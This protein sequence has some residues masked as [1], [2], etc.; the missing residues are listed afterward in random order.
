M[1]MRSVLS[2]VTALL[3]VG[4]FY[5][6]SYCIVE[7]V[8]ENAISAEYYYATEPE[9]TDDGNQ[10][11]KRKASGTYNDIVIHIPPVFNEDVPQNK[12][13]AETEAPSDENEPET[14]GSQPLPDAGGNAVTTLPDEVAD[15]GA[16]TPVSDVSNSNADDAPLADG[17]EDDDEELTVADEDGEII[18]EAEDNEVYAGD[19]TIDI[20]LASRFAQTDSTTVTVPPEEL[21]GDSPFIPAADIIITVNNEDMFSPPPYEPTAVNTAGETLYARYNGSVHTADAYELICMIVNNEVSASFNDEA[22]KAQAV[23]AYS[24]V[25]YHN[26]N[27]LTPTVLVKSNPPQIIKDLVAEVMGT[28]CYYGG[29]VAQTVYM[30]SSSGFTAS[31]ANVWGG[32]FPYLQ[33]VSCPFDIDN[34]PNYGK[35]IRFNEKDVKKALESS[36]GIMLSDNPQDWLRITGYADGNY[37]SRIDVDGQTTV[38]GRKLR[39]NILGYGLKSA[40]FDVSYSD[41]IF[42]FITYGYGHGVGMSQNGANYLGKQ[43]YSYQEILKYYFTGIEVY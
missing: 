18:L 19:E 1:N 20:M 33:S 3:L 29:N 25:K 14:G 32:D 7:E 15:E 11:N 2:G 41:G 30:A 39:E 23:A 13:P 17:S 6:F 40:A 36:L 43:G 12:K 37:V 24:Y 28:A 27:N 35:V 34:D 16:E 22:I 5:T 10:E 21:P 9:E 31:S 42:T 4:C 26:V 8:D 38:S